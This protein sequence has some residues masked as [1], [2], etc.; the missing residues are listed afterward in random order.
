MDKNT[1]ITDLQHYHP[2][3][4][5]EQWACVEALS[6]LDH[7]S[8]LTY[9]ANRAGHLTADVW[10]LSPDRQKVLLTLHH[11]FQAWVQLG[12]HMDEGET[13][14]ETALR[15]AYEESGIA[16]IKLLSPKI[17]DLDV[18]RVTA[19]PGDE[20]THYDFRFLGIAPSWDYVI[21]PESDDLRWFTPDEVMTLAVDHP[22]QITVTLRRMTQKWREFLTKM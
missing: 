17:F 18:H 3:D 16:G 19:Y 13:L 20:H 7:T 5:R 12:G 22:D 9:P 14:I 10:L 1:I 21:S 4:D 11:A 6:W 2:A 15:E 8:V